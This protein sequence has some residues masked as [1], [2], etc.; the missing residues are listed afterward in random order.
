MASEV[1][2]ILALVFPPKI[3]CTLIMEL[4]KT[5]NSQILVSRWSRRLRLRTRRSR[6]RT[7]RLRLRTRR[8]LPRRMLP[9]RMLPR[10]IL[11]R[12]KPLKRILP[13]R[14]LELPAYSWAS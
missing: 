9:R 13:R 4:T 10:R 8:I 12:T 6:L 3:H 2:V 7:R 11:L 14:L 1:E 5:F